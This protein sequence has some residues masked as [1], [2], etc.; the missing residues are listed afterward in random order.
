ME[1]SVDGTTL[2]L[3]VSSLEIGSIDVEFRNLVKPQYRGGG[4]SRTKS[5]STAASRKLVAVEEREKENLKEINIE[6]NQN[7]DKNIGS[8]DQATKSSD[9]SNSN[10]T[11]SIDDND[12]DDDDDE[13][14]EVFIDKKLLL[15]AFKA[16]EAF[17]ELDSRVVLCIKEERALTLHIIRKNKHNRDFFT[18]F[19]GEKFAS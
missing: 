18:I 5:S 14:K 16:A 3:A 8:I 6:E 7:V 10:S 15:K 17:E 11:N 12:S 19:I 1:V 13:E 4:Q 2:K 9:D